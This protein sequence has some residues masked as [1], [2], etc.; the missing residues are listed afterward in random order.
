MTPLEAQLEL[1]LP[2]APAQER[3]AAQEIDRL[4]ALHHPC[5]HT[6]LGIHPSPAGTILRAWRI[7]ARAM[8]V[9]TETGER[10]PMGEIREGLF[11]ARC[12]GETGWFRYTLF[13]ETPEG[14]T[15]SYQD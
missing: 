14:K 10:I 6:I 7:D 8:T 12:A 11:E 1:A 3:P 13:V 2:A 15:F 5:P 4:F 9:V